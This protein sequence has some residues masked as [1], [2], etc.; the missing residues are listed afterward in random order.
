MAQK[1][2]A[3]RPWVV[4]V[5]F[6]CVV[7]WSLRISNMGRWPILE[8]AQTASIKTTSEESRERPDMSEDIHQH[9]ASA[10]A[11]A[12][13]P[14]Q[15]YPSRFPRIV[16]QTASEHGKQKYADKADTW[17][18]VQGFQYNFLSGML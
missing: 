17:K 15:T 12:F 13:S 11:A 9:V 18:A 1:A 10:E 4:A 2:S 16:W 7:Y 14:Q 5:L 8:E 6:L 3:V